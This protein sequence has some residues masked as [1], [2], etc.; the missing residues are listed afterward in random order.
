MSINKTKLQILKE[1]KEGPEI[2]FEVTCNNCKYYEERFV[3]D[4]E[5]YDNWHTEI[6]CLK[7]NKQIYHTYNEFDNILLTEDDKLITPDYCPLISKEKLI[8]IIIKINE[9]L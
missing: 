4:E 2:K 1:N 6:T 9:S 8:D 3:E 7:I 5:G